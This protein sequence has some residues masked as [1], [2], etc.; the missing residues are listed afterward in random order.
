MMAPGA[1]ACTAI[2]ITVL[3]AHSVVAQPLPIHRWTGDNTSADAVTGAVAQLRNGT[4]FGPGR[5]GQAF[6]FDGVDDEID[7]GFLNSD[8]PAGSFTVAAW[9][10]TAPV[11]IGDQAEVFE[12]YECGGTCP[13]GLA[14]SLFQVYIAGPAGTGQPHTLNGFVRDQ[15][16]AGPDLGGQLLTVPAASIADGAFHH[17][18][19]VR[20]VVQATL[21]LYL[22]GVLAS[23]VALDPAAAGPL[24]GDAGNDGEVDPLTLGVHR[25]GG[26][27]RRGLRLHGA[28]DD[29]RLYHVALSG[30]DIAAL[31]APLSAQPPTLL[32]VVSVVGTQ[33]TIRWDPPAL[34]PTPT[35][36]V[37]EGGVAAGQTI[38]TI[39]LPV[40]PPVFSL[41]APV[42]A[43]FI[44]VR[45]R[46]GN[47]LSPPSNEA[48]LVTSVA[49]PSAPAAL[50]GLVN[51]STVALNWQNTFDGGEPTGIRLDV[52]GAA[53]ASL[54]LPLSE[55]FAFPAVPAGSYTFTVRET[56]AAGV[57]PA[58]APITLQFPA[59][60]T[61]APAA[62]Q[63]FLAYHQG[64]TL[65]LLWEPPGGAAPT[66]YVVRVSGPIS[67]DFPVGLLRRIVTLLP[68]GTYGFTV[69]ATNA[70]GTSAGTSSAPVVIP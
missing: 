32:E 23:S 40:D 43:F 3:M 42:G 37:L 64:A 5:F 67:G 26:E 27:T 53:T 34:G 58:S 8:Y 55:S 9:V 63:R 6:V 25:F 38:A 19:F 48:H 66:G 12:K 13:S 30:S 54:S 61:G 69:F 2:A 31:V 16:G 28:L 60:C 47:E 68:P 41:Q 62:P 51:G 57:G 17:V 35:G 52:T 33:A 10:K 7:T 50:S 44:R 36:Y 18:A 46:V 1:S 15:V 4:T 20:N 24:G 49:P 29:V 70:C 21:S 56:N 65:G 59:T 14:N 39:D 22:D 45:T 11:A